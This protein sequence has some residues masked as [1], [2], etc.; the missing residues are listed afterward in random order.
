M[1]LLSLLSL[2]DYLSSFWILYFFPSFAY[3]NAFRV[4][5]RKMTS[6][7]HQK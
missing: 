4:R 5:A 2:K 6:E 3:R 7:K 1:I